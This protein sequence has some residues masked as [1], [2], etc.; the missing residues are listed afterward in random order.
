[1]KHFLPFFCSVL[2][3]FLP[4]R[5]AVLLVGMLCIGFSVATAQ[6]ITI[7]GPNSDY[8]QLNAY[9][10]MATNATGTAWSRHGYVYPASLLQGLP[11]GSTI[12]SLEMPVYS[13][14]FLSGNIDCKIYLRPCIT[15]EFVGD[16][17]WADYIAPATLVYSGNPSNILS[18][19]DDYK[20]FPLSPTYKYAGGAIMVLVEYYQANAMQET[21]YWSVDGAV[22]IPEYNDKQSKHITGSGALPANSQF[23]TSSDKHPWIKINYSTGGS[24]PD[25]GGQSDLIIIGSSPKVG[26]TVRAGTPTSVAVEVVNYGP[27]PHSGKPIKC[28]IDGVLFSDTV[29]TPSMSLGQTALVQVGITTFT[30]GLH[31]IRF[32]IDASGDPNPASNDATFEIGVLS[33]IQVDLSITE[34]SPWSNQDVEA[35]T[36]INLTA[37]VKNLGE[38]PQAGIKV[39]CKIDGALYADTAKI[40]NLIKGGQ[41]TISVASAT[42]T[43]GQHLIEYSI[44]QL[45]DENTA[46]NVAAIL[47][48]ATAPATQKDLAVEA[49]TPTNNQVV[50]AGSPID[51]RAV[52]KNLGVL[53]QSNIAVTCTIDGVL[54]ADTATI[55]NL[56]GGYQITKLVT[57]ASF[58]PGSHTIKYAVNLAGDE[59][60]ANN[61]ITINITAAAIQKDLAI[62]SASPA[63]NQEVVAGT[64]IDLSVI[65]KNAG[66]LSQSSTPIFC[67]ID[68]V[69]YSDTA[70][71]PN[72][73][74]GQ[75]ATVAVSKANFSIGSHVIKYTLSLPGDE[76]A[77]NDVLRVC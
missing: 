52:V 10:P 34:A 43:T 18:T 61:S 31:T 50:A 57:K 8:D 55:A 53:A 9:G 54:Y 44:D 32:M 21:G 12:N 28:F 70:K 58:S 71:T 56:P 66:T 75:S 51:L 74:G 15:G 46:N 2:Q 76:N 22:S 45:K 3:K 23:A 24:D 64:P 69:I 5:T 63:N 1:M 60:A 25:P 30:P 42:F 33:P 6:T 40:P 73:P 49:N 11:G 27:A 67:T 14:A 16:S 19:S 20:K 7:A 48:Y 47:I 65:V 59:V 41:A 36:P 62:T 77:A 37:I 35:G 38:L 39:V 13:N 26:E 72:L 29:R 68:G 17:S 4:I